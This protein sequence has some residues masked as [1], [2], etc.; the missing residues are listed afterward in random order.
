[1]KKGLH[2]LRKTNLVVDFV[3]LDRRWWFVQIQSWFIGFVIVCGYKIKTKKEEQRLQ[4]EVLQEGK[5][6]VKRLKNVD[7]ENNCFTGLSG[8]QG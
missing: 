2:D 1:M 6:L 5:M 4:T 7:D 8:E 3:D